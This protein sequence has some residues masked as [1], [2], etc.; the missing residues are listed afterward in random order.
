MVASI[1]QQAYRHYIPRMGKPPG[2]MLD[3]YTVRVREGAV[4]VIEQATAISTF[5]GA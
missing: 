1:V 2:P 3:D 4:W 5:R